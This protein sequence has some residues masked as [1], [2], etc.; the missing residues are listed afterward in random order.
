MNTT[1]NI[2]GIGIPSNVVKVLT[3]VPVSVE[4]SGRTTG[5][6]KGSV[7]SFNTNV[8]V[9]YT[10]SCGGHKGFTISYV[11]QVVVVPGSFSAG[12]DSGSLIVTSDACHLP[13][14]L[15][16]AGSSSSTIGNPIGEVLSKAG[17]ALGSSITFVGETCR[18]A[19]TAQ[20]QVDSRGGQT[21]V[22]AEQEIANATAAMRTRE[23]EIMS[24]SGVLGIGVGASAVN[25]S[26]AVIIVYLD[27]T[28]GVTTRLPRRIGGV[29]VERIMTDP[30]V[31]Y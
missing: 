26:E 22:I 8:L 3:T 14:A 21:P 23:S 16:F 31:A 1:G 18:T 4:K 28:L 11:N 2:E 24:R 29:R 6:T 12:G 7:Q 10:T 9:K 20:P 17:A 19:N 15:L 25:S 30:F 13:V 27:Q 5:V